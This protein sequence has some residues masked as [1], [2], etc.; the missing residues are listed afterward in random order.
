MVHQPVENVDR[1]ARCAGNDFNM[2]WC[3]AIG[4][5]RIELDDRVPAIVCVDVSAGFSFAAK[6]EMLAIRR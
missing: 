4:D 1:F 6:V 3:V 5:M 2:E